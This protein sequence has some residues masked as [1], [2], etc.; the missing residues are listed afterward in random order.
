VSLAAG[1][2]STHVPRLMIFS[3]EAR[4]AY[5]GGRIS[6]FYEALARIRTEKIAPLEIETFVVVDTHWQTTLD[7][8]INAHERL[9][10]VYTSDELPGMLAEYE[11]DYAG[12]PELGLAITEE[13]RAAGLPVLASAHRGLP[14]H[15]GTLN[16]MHYYNPGP[17]KAR[18]LSLS[19]CITAEIEPNLRMGAAISRAVERVGR[20]ALLVASGGMSHRFWPLSLIRE[21]A[22]ADPRDV[23]S[24]ELRAWDERIMAWWRGGE[25]AEVLAHTAEFRRTASPEGGFAH[26]LML[27]GA[28]GGVRW[29]APGQQF[30]RYEAA[31]GTGQANFWFDA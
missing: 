19:V 28:F 26:Y 31:I 14:L 10:G 13:A 21:R 18:V 24:P 6:T 15:Y 9:A 20:R 23:S 11:F 29:R 1:L 3:E 22:G 27:A 12:D 4:R 30:G 25:H 17:N 16:P 2:F 5:M 7:F 8:A